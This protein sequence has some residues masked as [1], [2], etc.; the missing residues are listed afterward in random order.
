VVGFHP[1]GH[2]LEEKEGRKE[3]KKGRGRRERKRK[4]GKGYSPQ[5]MPPLNTF[6]ESPRVYF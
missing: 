6:S 1:Q 4:T 3:G 2:F 5:M